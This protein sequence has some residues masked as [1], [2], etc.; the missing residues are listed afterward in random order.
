MRLTVIIPMYNESARIEQSLR[1]L[2]AALSSALDAADFEIL[3]ANDGSTD[4]TPAIVSALEQELPGLRLLNL[5]RNQGK[6]G[7]VQRGMLEAKGAFV[8]FTDS[9]LAYGTDQ[10]LLFLEAFEQG[11]GKAILVDVA[12]SLVASSNLKCRCCS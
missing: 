7:A 12:G 9:D 10:I 2:H 4:E 1:T 11:K 8:L 3:A 5:D 6:G